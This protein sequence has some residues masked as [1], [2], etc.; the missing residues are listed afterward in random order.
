MAP[1]KPSAGNGGRNSG[2]SGRASGAGILATPGICREAADMLV[3][4]G[5]PCMRRDTADESCVSPTAPTPSEATTLAARAG[6]LDRC[7]D[8][9]ANNLESPAFAQLEHSTAMKSKVVIYNQKM[10]GRDT[11]DQ[12]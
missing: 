1:D 6:D 4:V 9:M 11:T 3:A 10:K 5:S 7:D 8:A 2:T 12:R